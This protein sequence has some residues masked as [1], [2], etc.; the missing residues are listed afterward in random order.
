MHSQFCLWATPPKRHDTNAASEPLISK[1]ILNIFSTWKLDCY[2]NNY[3]KQPLPLTSYLIDKP[4][5]GLIYYG[6]FISKQDMMHDIN[7]L[8]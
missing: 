8:W 4:N 7:I 3:T 5:I 6:Y 1:S 2:P